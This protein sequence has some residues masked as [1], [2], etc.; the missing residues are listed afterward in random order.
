MEML[1]QGNQLVV[2]FIFFTICFLQPILLPFPEAATVG[3]GGAVLGSFPAASISFVGTLSGIMVAYFIAKYGGQKLIK[4]WVKENHIKQYERY[5]ARNEISILLILFIIPILP[6]EIICF[7]AGISGVSFKKFL[8]IAGVAKLITSFSLAYSVD[9]AQS[10]A[11][12]NTQLSFL[13]IVILGIVM[14]TSCISK[15]MLLKRNN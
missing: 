1:L 7:G 14:L 8:L 6:D 5:V 10:L 2:A 12:N 15:K 9:F 11:L 3:A 13:V 4:K